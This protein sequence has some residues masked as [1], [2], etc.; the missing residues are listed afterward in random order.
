MI[1]GSMTAE[2]P[3]SPALPRWLVRD[4]V[5][6]VTLLVAQ[7]AMKRFLSDGGIVAALLSP[8]GAHSVATLTVALL[9]IVVRVA[10]VVGV[11]AYVVGKCCELAVARFRR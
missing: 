10:L 4:V 5:L 7:E 8:G 9:L 6:V 2:R 1:T 3:R 11:P